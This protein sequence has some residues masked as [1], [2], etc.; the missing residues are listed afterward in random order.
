MVCSAR[1]EV[2]AGCI[3]RDRAAGE[4]GRQEQCRNQQSHSVDSFEG[5]AIITEWALR[6]PN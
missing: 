1:H 6:R 2:T 5:A 3:N 4:G